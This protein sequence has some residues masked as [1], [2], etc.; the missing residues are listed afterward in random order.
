MSN[1]REMLSEVPDAESAKPT[2]DLE[3]ENLSVKEY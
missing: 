3:L 1:S 2:A